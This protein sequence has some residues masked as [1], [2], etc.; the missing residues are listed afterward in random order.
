[1]GILAQFRHFRHF[2]LPWGGG[3]YFRLIPYLPFKYGVKSIL[4]NENAYLFFMHPWEIDPKQPR[5]KD[6]ITAYKFRHYTN[7]N[8]TETRLRNFIE[9]FDYCRFVTCKKYLSETI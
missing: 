1:L 4:K 8:K 3:G 6:A 5:V 2:H 9:S 7:L